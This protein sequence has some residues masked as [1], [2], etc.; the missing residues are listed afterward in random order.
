TSAG[1]TASGTR[2]SPPSLS[3]ATPSTASSV[4]TSHLFSPQQGHFRSTLRVSIKR[5][6]AARLI[7][8]SPLGGSV[9]DCSSATAFPCSPCVTIVKLSAWFLNETRPLLAP[10]MHVIRVA[11]GEPIRRFT[12]PT[13]GNDGYR[14]RSY[15]PRL[16]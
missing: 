3:M 16:V 11:S 4:R 10:S 9:A 15:L 2:A 5:L 6:K 13:G 1:S 8:G 12:D 7:V 14:A